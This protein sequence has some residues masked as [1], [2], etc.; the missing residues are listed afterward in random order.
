MDINPFLSQFNT[1]NSPFIVQQTLNQLKAWVSASPWFKG[2]DTT[3]WFTLS[4]EVNQDLQLNYQKEWTDIGLKLMMQQPFSFEDR[5]FRDESWT[6]PLFGSI[7][8]Y[9]LLNSKFVTRLVEE[10][11]IE[12]GKPRQRLLYLIEQALAA[13]APSNFLASNP[14]ALQ[15]AVETGGSSLLNGAMQFMSDLQEGK[16]RQSDIGDFKVGETL[17]TTEGEVV[18]ENDLFQLIQYKPKTDKQYKTPMLIVPPWINK[19]YILDLSHKNSMV[20][21]ILE[22]GHPLFV[23]SW[24]NFNTTHAHLSWDDMVQQGV[25]NAISATRSITG[26]KKINMVGYCIGGLLLSTTLAVLADRGDTDFA[27]LTYFTTL[28]DYEDT[29]I[30]DIFID[31]D[32]MQYHERTIGG[33]D[34]GHPG[35]FRGRDMGNTFALLRPNELW[36]NYNVDKYLKGEKPRALDMLYWNND[37]TNFPGKMYCWYLRHNYLQNDVKQGN[38]KVCGVKIDYKEIVQPTYIVGAE[39]DHIVPWQGAYAS[40]QVLGGDNIRFVLGASGHIAGI[41]NPPASK[42]RS[43]W[44]NDAITEDPETWHKNAKE[45]AG[46]WWVDW[47]EWLKEQSG[48]KV[49]SVQQLG[50]AEFPPLEPAPGRYVLE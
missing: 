48:E 18:F 40:T 4:E 50:S 31:E 45:H 35:L 16:M 7:A 3:Q 36:W 38:V 44:T 46:S 22:E 30:L 47:F 13:S 19:Y 32:L 25:V 20:R 43:Y 28:L 1:G 33:E 6:Q 27:S 34:G 2:T 8:A 41:I 24:R 5:R 49:D 29:G 17:A 15:R 26:E 37:G 23:I 42:K 9:Y 39:Q 21:H 10:L 12:E 14:E 11:P